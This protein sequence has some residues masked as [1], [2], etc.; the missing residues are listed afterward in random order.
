[1]QLSLSVGDLSK[2]FDWGKLVEASP[3]VT[4]SLATADGISGGATTDTLVI[5]FSGFT[6]GSFV[7]FRTGISA[8]DPGASMIHDYRMTLFELD[9]DDDTSANSTVSVKFESDAGEETLEQQM[10]NFAMGGMS[11][12]TTMAFPD[13]Y[14]DS[15]MPFTLEGQGTIGGEDPEDPEDPE[16]PEPTPE[17]PEPGS[18][19]LLA[20]GLLGLATWRIKRR[21]RAA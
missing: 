10:P 18:F 17:V 4:F 15:V 2:N 7:R 5:N 9:G 16:E 12:S 1:M 6:P 8:D 21:R 3:G 20:T 11:T 14:M 19:V 13:H